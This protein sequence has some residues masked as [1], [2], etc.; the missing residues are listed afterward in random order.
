MAINLRDLYDQYN[1]NPNKLTPV[2][3]NTPFEYYTNDPEFITD[4]LG[5]ARFVAQ[6]L[7]VTGPQYN[8]TTRR[9]NA[10][11]A[12]LN[13]TD[14]TVYAAFE[15]AVTTYGNM[16]Y[17]FKIRDNYINLEGSDTLPFFHNLISYVLST[18]VGSPVTWSSARRAT[19]EEVDLDPAYSQSVSDGEIYVISSSVADYVAPNLDLIKSFN[20]GKMLLVYHWAQ[21]FFLKKQHLLNFTFSILNL[22]FF[23]YKKSEILKIPHSKFL[24]K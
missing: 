7:G 15:E 18:E 3:G 22:N 23:E 8:F 1:G 24:I 10:S 11:A 5:V 12:T 21:I 20:L 16:V 9:F 6:R 14:L 19:W 2:K 4:A 13:I 17:Q